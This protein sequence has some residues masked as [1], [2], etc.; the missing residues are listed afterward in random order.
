MPC[1]LSA[2]SHHCRLD[3]AEIIGFKDNA[4]GRH[5]LP[6]HR[7]LD[8][9]VTQPALDQHF[10]HACSSMASSTTAISGQKPDMHGG[11]QMNLSSDQQSLSHPSSEVSE[12]KSLCVNQSTSPVI[13][14][15][16]SKTRS[17][18]PEETAAPEW[19][20]WGN[21]ASHVVQKDSDPNQ[22][23]QKKKKPPRPN[24]ASLLPATSLQ[25]HW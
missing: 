24:V 6:E 18:F 2:E 3:N 4:H 7:N 5:S 23:S 10:N 13:D 12:C 9:S 1:R 21:D 22:R 11:S 17:L 19:G 25:G 15:S 20:S 8:E 14:N 16:F